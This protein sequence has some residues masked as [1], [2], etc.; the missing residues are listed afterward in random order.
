MN[1]LDVHDRVRADRQCLYAASCELVDRFDGVCVPVGPVE[2]VFKHRD[3]ERSADLLTIHED[4]LHIRS[5]HHGSA[6]LVKFSINPVDSL[7]NVI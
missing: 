2:G 5:V 3:G 1:D 7:S 6:D 4:N